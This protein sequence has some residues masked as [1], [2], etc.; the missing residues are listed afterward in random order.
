M[1]LHFVIAAALALAACA[2]PQEGPLP[3]PSAFQGVNAGDRAAHSAGHLIFLKG[4]KPDAKCPSGYVYCVTLSSGHPAQLYFC[5]STGSYCGPSHYPLMWSSGF[6]VRKGD[7]PTN[8]FTASFS[9]NPGDPTYDTIGEAVPVKSTHRRYKY[10]QGVCA[11]S[12]GSP[13]HGYFLV[14]IAVK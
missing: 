7:K 14:G 5:Y 1:K 9:P 6:I 3:V 8:D 11:G 10:A 12:S 2:T 4:I 13:C